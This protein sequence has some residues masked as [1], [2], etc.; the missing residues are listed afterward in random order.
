MLLVMDSYLKFEN[1]VLL[2]VQLVHPEEAQMK[3]LHF[4]LTNRL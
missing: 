3:R 1:V 2:H 4:R